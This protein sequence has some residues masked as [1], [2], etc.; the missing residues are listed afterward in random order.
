MREP[1]GLALSSRNVRLSPQE[2]E[3][4]LALSRGAAGR[5]GAS[6]R[7]GERDAARAARRRAP[8]AAPRA[9]S[10]PSTSRSSTPT[11]FTPLEQRSTAAYCSSVAA[12]VGPARLIDNAPR[13]PPTAATRIA[14]RQPRQGAVHVI[15]PRPPS[16]AP[17]RKRVTLTKLAEMRALGEPI[18]MV[19]AYDHPSARRRRGGRRR[20]RAGR[21]LR[22]QQRARLRGHG[23]RD[24]RGAA[25]ARRRRPPRPAARRCWSA[26]CRS[27]PTRPPT[28]R[29]S[30]PRTASSRRPAATPSSSRAAAPRP[31]ARARSCAPASP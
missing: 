19:T 22:R 2:R 17:A 25:D 15:R 5:R 29:R 28:R 16:D 24:G 21:R 10:S 3:R 30:P 14:G 11:T 12:R 4:A 20:R 26:T 7:A 9:A 18:V 27:A 31:S 13:P 6:P 8:R 23:A 1:D